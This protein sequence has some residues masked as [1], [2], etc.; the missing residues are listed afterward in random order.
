MGRACPGAGILAQLQAEA[1]VV[2]CPS[3]HYDLEG[4]TGHA[5]CPECGRPLRARNADVECPNCREQVPGGFEICW[6]C[7][8][9]IPDA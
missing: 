7:G 8:A 3:C 2:R 5:M 9:G 6:N 4:H 1:T